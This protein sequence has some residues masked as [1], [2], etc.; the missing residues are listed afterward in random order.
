MK[1]EMIGKYVDEHILRMMKW[2][3]YGVHLEK[4]EIDR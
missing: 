1:E 2:V 4:L 3:D